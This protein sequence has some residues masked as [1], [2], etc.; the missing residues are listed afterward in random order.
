[1]ILR[2]RSPDGAYRID[3]Q[4]GDDISVLL[5][6][7][8]AVLPVGVNPPS[9][10]LSDQPHNGKTRLL[11]GLGGVSIKDTGLKHGDLL[12][13]SYSKSEDG[14]KGAVQQPSLQQSSGRLNGQAIRPGEN[15]SLRSKDSEDELK[16]VANPWDTITQDPI[17]NQLEKMDGK[18]ARGRDHKMCKHG[19]KGMCDYCMPLEPYDAAYLVEKK[20]KHLSF[21]SYLRKINTATN[22]PENP[23][24][25]IPP[26]TEPYFRVKKNCPSGHAPWP[27]GICAKCQPSAITLKPQEFR[28]VDHV[29]FSDPG[30]IDDFI[31]YWRASGNQRIG[32]LYGRYVPY[33]E[34]PLGIKAVVEAI[35]EA[36]Q[37]GE[38]DGVTL[39]LPWEGEKSV[40]EVAALCG[41]RK[42]GVI[43]TDLVDDGTG[44]GTVLCKRHRDSYF[45]S[46]LEIAF[47]AR[48]QAAHPNPCRWSETGRFGSKFVTCV[49][50]GNDEGGIDVASYQV[51]NTAVEMVRAD[52]VEA[53]A[54]PSVM[55]IREEDDRAR[56]VPEV[57]YR[58]INEYGASVQENAKVSFPVD[59]LLVTLTHGFP[60]NPDPMFIAP[61]G[62]FPVENRE[63]IGQA[64]D[65]SAIAKQLN[66]VNGRD[67]V[68]AVSDFHM[69]CFLH[70]MGI[71]DKNEEKLLA[72]VA[73]KH[74][75]SSGVALQQTPGWQ[76]LL[77]ILRESGERPPKHNLF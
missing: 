1:M 63:I 71:L 28:M 51:S 38:S 34:V 14:E 25:Y 19:T 53:S 77:T 52:I 45:L 21:H 27:D 12:F 42:I 11:S 10:V 41:L 36:P 22:K 5:E 39:S 3:V 44:Q 58:R 48:L 31:N 43:F 18:I 7:L 54:D 65:L 23:T 24:S 72:E 67:P 15:I 35:F 50:S 33:L 62:Q 9:I 6:K 73:S 29:E 37:V 17:D 76:T 2:F 68:Q 60:H 64:Q 40:D 70:T 47:A 30:L 32:Y 16:K 49:V 46:S 59:Y 13:L 8:M 4:P 74:D 56:Y 69:L 26:L 75:V 66:S 20:I 61:R 57:F 55:L